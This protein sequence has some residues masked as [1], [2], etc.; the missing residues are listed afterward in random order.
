[1]LRIG[2]SPIKE[3]KPY[4]HLLATRGDGTGKTQKLLGFV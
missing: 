3:L 4:R 2:E 1:M